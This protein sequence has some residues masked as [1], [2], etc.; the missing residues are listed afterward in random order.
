ML[1]IQ[2][3]RGNNDSNNSPINCKKCGE[4]NFPAP[5]AFWNI[6]ILVHSTKD[7]KP[8]N[9]ITLVKGELKNKDGFIIELII[10]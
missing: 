9:M 2:G 7:V 10:V 8:I 5:H 1:K 4:P 3:R 6:V